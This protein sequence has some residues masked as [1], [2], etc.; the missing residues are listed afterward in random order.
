MGIFFDVDF[1]G[2][3]HTTVVPYGQHYERVNRKKC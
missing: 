2:G 1:N 3:N